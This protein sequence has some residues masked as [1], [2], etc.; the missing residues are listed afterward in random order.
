GPAVARHPQG[1]VVGADPKHVGVQRRLGQGRA[2]ALLG[3]RDLRG[4]GLQLVAPLDRAEDLLA[5]AV[6]DARVVAGQD[7]RRVPVEAVPAAPAATTTARPTAAAALLGPGRSGGT[8]LAT[9][10]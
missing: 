2:A 5:G 6:E 4:D 7:E 9:A 8:R 1:A 3:A 10:A